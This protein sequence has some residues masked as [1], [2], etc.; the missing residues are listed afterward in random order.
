MAKDILTPTDA[1]GNPGDLAGNGGD[2]GVP[3]GSELPT[4]DGGRIPNKGLERIRDASRT[5]D[6]LTPQKGY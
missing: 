5:A 4:G 6:I 2:A 3:Y 1:P